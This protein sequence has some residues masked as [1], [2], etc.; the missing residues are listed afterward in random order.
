MRK[1]TLL[2]AL[3]LATDTLGSDAATFRARRQRVA[4]AFHDGI[5]LIHAVPRMD[6]ALD[7][8]RQDPYFNYLTGQENAVGAILAVEGKS[9]ESWL[10]LPS[11]PP[12]GK[13]GLKPP[14]APGPQASQQTGIEHVVDWTEL[15]T[16]LAARAASSPTLYY[17]LDGP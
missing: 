5:L 13:Y 14:V 3:L 4:L 11:H 17:A 15:A 6:I 8:Y 16:F 7:G 2:L 12:F 10:F 9:A 1:A